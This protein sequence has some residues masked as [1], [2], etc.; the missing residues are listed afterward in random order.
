MLTHLGHETVHQS[1]LTY[2]GW[3]SDPV[4]DVGVSSPYALPHHVAQ[5]ERS[6]L[7]VRN[8][9]RYLVTAGIA[10]LFTAPSDHLIW[11]ARHYGTYGAAFWIEHTRQM[12][13]V[14]D[15]VATLERITTDAPHAAGV[16]S[17][18]VGAEITVLQ[19]TAAYEAAGRVNVH[20]PAMETA[21]RLY[22]LCR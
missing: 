5:V 16:F 10:Q 18:L 4:T 6:L 15:T 3:V 8:P 20:N 19:I 22:D 13:L 12:S 21:D 14:V 9:A 7:I 1:P 2:D 17:A 11:I